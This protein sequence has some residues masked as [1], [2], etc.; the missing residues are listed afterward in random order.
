MSKSINTLEKLQIVHP[1]QQDH[2]EIAL[3][4][5]RQ[6]KLKELLIQSSKPFTPV[7]QHDLPVEKLSLVF[8]SVNDE[9]IF[10]LSSLIEKFKVSLKELHLEGNFS[11][12]TYEILTELRSLKTLSL[13]I[14][15]EI[16]FDLNSVLLIESVEILKINNNNVIDLATKFPNV[17]KL[18]IK[19][20]IDREMWHLLSTN[21][22]ELEQIELQNENLARLENDTFGLIFP[23]VKL[24][25]T[26]YYERVSNE[27]A[28]FMLHISFPNIKYFKIDELDLINREED[29]LSLVLGEFNQLETVEVKKLFRAELPTLFRYL[30]HFVNKKLIVPA[31]VESLIRFEV[32]NKDYWKEKLPLLDDYLKK[33]TLV[34][35]Q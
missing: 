3:L 1:L 26:K 7:L 30:D 6:S 33:G 14:E 19:E 25:Q 23:M 16:K 28:Q 9:M 27:N 10:N 12:E 4:I 21:M 31:T 32:S 11:L 17:K 5:N 22:L 20:K 34:L 8:S 13:F 35:K 18:V 15:D 24:L 29:I 2:Q